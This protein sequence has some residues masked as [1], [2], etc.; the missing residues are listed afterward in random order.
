MQ[1]LKKEAMA[2]HEG[3]STGGPLGGPLAVSVDIFCCHDW[4]R[5]YGP[6]I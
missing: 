5:G 2:P 3:F 1:L 4:G 6:G